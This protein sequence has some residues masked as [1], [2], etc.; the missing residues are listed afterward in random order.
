MAWRESRVLVADVRPARP[1]ARVRA[2]VV[3]DGMVASFLLE[4]GCFFLFSKFGGEE[5]VEET[6]MIMMMMDED[7]EEDFCKVSLLVDI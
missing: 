5:D 4:K 6:R 1:R 3:K 7:E 2:V